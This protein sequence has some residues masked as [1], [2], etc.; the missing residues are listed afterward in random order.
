MIRRHIIP[1]LGTI[2]LAQLSGQHLQTYY[3]NKLATGRVDGNGGLSARTVH[4]D[5]TLTRPIGLQ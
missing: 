1:A 3:A 2:P 4:Q 5:L